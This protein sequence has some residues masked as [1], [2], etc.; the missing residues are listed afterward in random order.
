MKGLTTMKPSYDDYRRIWQLLF[1]HGLFG[2]LHERFIA[3]VCDDE[4]PKARAMIDAVM[5]ELMNSGSEAR[6]YQRTRAEVRYV[7]KTQ[8]KFFQYSVDC[9]MRRQVERD[10]RYYQWPRP[11]P[12]ERRQLQQEGEDL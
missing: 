7:V 6:C 12:R 9:W 5:D 8:W 11:A 1:A 4:P 2:Y 10:R 3:L